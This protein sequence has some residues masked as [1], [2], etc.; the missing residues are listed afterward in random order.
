MLEA[1]ST[2]HGFRK[3]ERIE[4]QGRRCAPMRFRRDPHRESGARVEASDT[5]GEV[6]IQGASNDVERPCHS[7]LVSVQGIPAP[8]AIG[9]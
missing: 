1:I 6:E 7:G 3:C 8:A 5:S 9:I 4:H 2:F